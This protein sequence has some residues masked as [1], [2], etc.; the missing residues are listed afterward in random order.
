MAA[1]LLVAAP[2]PT[3]ELVVNDEAASPDGLLAPGYRVAQ[4]RSLDLN[5]DGKTEVVAL[6]VAANGRVAGLVVCRRSGRRRVAPLAAVTTD[7]GAGYDDITL[8]G[9]RIDLDGDGAFELAIDERVSGAGLRLR[10]RTF[11]QLS[12]GR[13]HRV[14]H[15]TETYRFRGRSETRSFERRP[16][17]L[18]VERI[19]ASETDGSG[20]LRRYRW[21]VEH[22]WDPRARRFAPSSTRVLR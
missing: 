1:A 17:G 11:W 9:E 22:R 20:T 3:P 12:G 19:D 14:Y 4:K 2:P 18:L 10:S 15:I 5:G 8:S 7:Y 13:L 21:S 6:V 16:G